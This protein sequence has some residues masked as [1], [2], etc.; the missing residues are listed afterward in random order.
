MRVSLA[1]EV[2]GLVVAGAIA[3]SGAG[4]SGSSAP[5]A[6]A[7]DA[8]GGD[9]AGN[10]CVGTGCSPGPSD[11]GG[12]ADSG[13]P[14]P[15]VDSGPAPQS[16]TLSKL[17]FTVVGDTRP[18]SPDDTQGY[19]TS[20][21]D[22]IYQDIAALNPAPAFSVSTGDYM[23][24]STWGTQ[25]GAQ[26]DLYLAARAKF[27]GAFY[28]AMGNHECTGATASNCGQGNT[29]GITSNFSAFLSKMLGP[30]QQT[31]PY[32]SVN[33]K[34]ADG[35][36]TSKFVF[37]AA[38]AWDAA[39]SSWLQGVMG[40]S[41]TYTFV[42]RHESSYANTAPGVSPTDQMLGGFPYTL[43]IV[44]H[45]HTYEHPGTKEVL[46]GNGGAPLSGSGNYGYGLFEQRSDGAIQVDA[47]DYQSNQ[48]DMSFRFAVKPDGTPTQ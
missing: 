45:S 15:P 12:G 24:A 10:G 9:D 22:Q 7:A 48:P 28:P 26:L 43:L 38:N 39:Q 5:V 1:L 13:S 6:P 36:W 23:F 16:T 42:V 30:I 29:D 17:I 37:I 41:T 3:T 46:F 44:G 31:Q 25:A 19:P 2:G 18:A 34:A 40:Q 14:P 8:G 33:F 4:C 35:S 20:I 32:Y 27:S 11:E 47:M 21:I